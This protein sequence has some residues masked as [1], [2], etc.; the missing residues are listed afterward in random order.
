[1]VL[2]ARVLNNSNQSV[3]ILLNP[4]IDHS[5]ITERAVAKL[6]LRKHAIWPRFQWG[7]YPRDDD[8]AVVSELVALTIVPSSEIKPIAGSILPR[9]AE[10]PAPVRLELVVVNRE[11]SADRPLTPSL[12][13]QLQREFAVQLT[14]YFPADTLQEEEARQTHHVD[15]VVGADQLYSAF[16]ADGPLVKRCSSYSIPVQGVA[17]IETGLLRQT[18]TGFGAVFAAFEKLYKSPEEGRRAVE[19]ERSYLERLYQKM[20]MQSV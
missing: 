17:G 7:L 2:R 13:R 5:V 8:L 10:P 12:H 4:C 20:C 1:M 18:S 15:I 9:A 11:L 14:D 3:R 19:Q 6:G 16:F